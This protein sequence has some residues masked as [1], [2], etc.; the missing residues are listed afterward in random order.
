MGF[1]LQISKALIA[2]FF[3]TSPHQWD[4]KPMATKYIEGN[5]DTVY[6]AERRWI[7][8]VLGGIVLDSSTLIP[9]D[10]ALNQY[11]VRVVYINKEDLR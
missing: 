9:V 2:I 4:I 8:S 7:D 10:A 1:Y 3:A 6:V 11:S 5:G